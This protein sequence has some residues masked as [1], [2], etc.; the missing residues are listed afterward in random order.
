MAEDKDGNKVQCSLYDQLKQSLMLQSQ[1]ENT[2]IQM[3]ALVSQF[4]NGLSPADL[5]GMSER[6]MGQCLWGD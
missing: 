6:F 3:I 2:S 5:K 1:Q 4:E